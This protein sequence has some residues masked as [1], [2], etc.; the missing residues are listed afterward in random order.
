MCY[1]AAKNVEAYEETLVKINWLTLNFEQQPQRERLLNKKIR[2]RPK[3]RNPSV[4]KTKNA[5]SKA[6]CV[7]ESSRKYR[8]C[9]QVKHIVRTCFIVANDST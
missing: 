8:K 3:L 7:E 2:A 6:K 1:N 4:V 5:I 9:R